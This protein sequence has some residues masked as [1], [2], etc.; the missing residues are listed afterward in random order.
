[1]G[2]KI[3]VMKLRS[4]TVKVNQDGEEEEGGEWRGIDAGKAVGPERVSL[5]RPFLSA[6]FRKA[7]GGI[8]E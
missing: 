4:E 5:R 1:M 3:P 8:T 7:L 6:L 2:V